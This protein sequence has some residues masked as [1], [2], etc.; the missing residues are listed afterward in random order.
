MLFTVDDA[1]HFI[2]DGQPGIGLWASTAVAV[3]AWE[4]GQISANP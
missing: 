3:D 2:V 4:G 1:E